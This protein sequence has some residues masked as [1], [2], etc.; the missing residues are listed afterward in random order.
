[1]SSA[2]QR[3]RH[4]LPLGKVAVGYCKGYTMTRIANDLGLSHHQVRDLIRIEHDP[5]YEHNVYT[6]GENAGK[7]VPPL[8][9]P[10][11]PLASLKT[12]A[13]NYLSY[14]KECIARAYQRLV[15]GRV[16][17]TLKPTPQKVGERFVI[18]DM[19]RRRTIPNILNRQDIQL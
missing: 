6:R 17:F 9:R 14:V 7:K 19:C 15:L 18:H 10:R 5:Y 8:P 3:P 13:D 1:M 2:A 4:G 12:P 11:V 16:G